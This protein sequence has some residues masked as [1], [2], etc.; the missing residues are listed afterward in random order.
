MSRTEKFP[1]LFQEMLEKIQEFSMSQ[2]N[3]PLKN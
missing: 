3:M 2:N 1:Y